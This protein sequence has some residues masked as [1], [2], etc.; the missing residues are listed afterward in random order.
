MWECP[1][2]GCSL[3]KQ[4]RPRFGGAFRLDH[5]KIAPPA[6]R[7]S[8][9]PKITLQIFQPANAGLVPNALE[10]TDKWTLV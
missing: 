4:T 5:N 2:W 10:Q 9:L 3:L 6:G 1:S 8:F 7:G